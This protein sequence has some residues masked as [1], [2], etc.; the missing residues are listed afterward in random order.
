M[1]LKILTPT[2][3]VLDEQ[4]VSVVAEGREGSF[5]LRPRHADYVSVLEPGLLYYET[6]PSGVDGSPKEGSFVAVDRG[7]LVKSGPEVLVSVRNAVCGVSLGDLVR[8][9][10]E[11]FLSLNE[12]ERVV[13]SALARLESDFVRRFMELR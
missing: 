4:V 2:Q 6:E 8:A 1:T 5:G 13:R 3:V 12:H 7:I 10:R 11:Q 9:V